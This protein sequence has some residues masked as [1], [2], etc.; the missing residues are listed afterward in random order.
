MAK[1]HRGRRWLPWVGLAASLLVIAVVAVVVVV[2]GREGDVSNPGADFRQTETQAASSHGAVQKP[3]KL[4][5][6]SD[7]GF[8][9]PLFGYNLQRTRVLGLK[10]LFRPPF[11]VAWRMNAHQLL[12]FSPV[13]CQRSVYLLGDSGVLFK[14]SRWTGQVEWR[15]K[16]GDLAA[17]SPACSDGIVYSVLLR[18]P[19]SSTGRIV[20]LS[21][22]FGHVRWSHPLPARAESSPLLDHGHLY[23]GTEDGS[24]YALNAHSGHLLW[25]TRTSGAVKGSLALANGKLY[26]G[27][28]GGAVYALRQSN[29]HVVW[30]AAVA[31]GGAFGLG[32]GNFYATP[33]IEYGRVYIG[34]TN[35]AIYSLVARTGRL[36]WRKQTGNYVY[37][38]AAV[39]AVAGGRP[40]VWV[41]SYNGTF[42]A[43]DARSGAVRWTRAL[44]GK[45]SGSATVLGDLVFVSSF[46]RRTT[47]AVGA[48]TGKV[49][50]RWPRGAFTPAIS[51][52]RRIYFNGF[53]SLYGL[54]PKG[55]QY[56]KRARPRGVPGLSAQKQRAAAKRQRAAA[57]KRRAAARRRAAAKRRAAAA[58]RARG[59]TC[60]RHP[61]RCH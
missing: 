7:D 6:P 20:A 24:V 44:G 41:G 38:S 14:I 54:D 53:G 17:S 28:Y 56:A 22:D 50:W 40:T 8:K 42:Y 3:P 23:F 57:A 9:W 36:A 1:R 43:L 16:L 58:K 19:G 4:G 13:L 30:R 46:D 18:A 26:F 61:K 37:A 32:G 60:R 49:V 12:E 45:L 48:N 25:R 59:R 39:G 15:R 11:R 21:T 35:G 34:A 27:T 51:D 52:G 29:G 10:R 2:S 5:H 31:S 47:W 55:E 33:A